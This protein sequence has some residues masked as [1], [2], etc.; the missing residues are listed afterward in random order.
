M[1]IRIVKL[2]IKKENSEQFIQ[3]FENAQPTIAASPGCE[4]VELLRD[5]ADSGLF[6][7]HSHWTG[8]QDLEAYRKSEFFRVTWAQ[9]KLLFSN[10]PEAWSLEKF[11]NLQG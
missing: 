4:H 2:S 9:T 11:V 7:T 3:L 8:A 10:K 1:I 5:T 6:F